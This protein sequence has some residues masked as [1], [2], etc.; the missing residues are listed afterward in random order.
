[1][2]SEPGA[3]SSSPPPTPPP[4]PDGEK[5]GRSAW[6][7]VTDVLGEAPTTAAAPLRVYLVVFVQGAEGARI[8][9]IEEGQEVVFGRSSDVSFPIEDTRISRRHAA[10]RK[11]GGDVFVKDLG[12]RN[13]TKV[14]GEVLR[15]EE[16]LVAAGDT[17][18]LGPAEI[19]V[20]AVTA[21]GGS[22]STVPPDANPLASK[23][24][25]PDDE[26]AEGF[27]G[28]VVADP[29]MQKVFRLARRLG[30]TP[31]T[32]LILGETGSGKEVVAEQIHR[33]SPRV[34]GPFVRLNCASLSETLLESELFGHEKGAF[35][36]AD[37]RKIGYIEAANGGTLLL[38]EIGEL[39][40]QTQVKLLRVLETKCVA[41]LGGTKEVPVDVRFVCAT[42]R[43]LKGEVS[44][45]RF[46]EDLYYRI[47]TFTLQVPPLRERPAEITLL[48]DLFAAHFAKKMDAKPPV[49][50]LDAQQVLH[51]FH[52]PGNV[53]EL[54]NAVEH[55]VVLAE[56]GTVLP[57]HLPDAVRHPSEKLS[58]ENARAIKEQFMEVEKK[59]IEAALAA[60]GQNQTRAAKRL[61]ITR[62]MLI[63]KMGKL[64]IRRA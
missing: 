43:N 61:G 40:L 7:T 41:R 31:T 1:M 22:L 33:W 50:S 55:A 11:A 63:Y 8:V 42:H 5:A 28:I 62:R 56:E 21:A 14:R 36:G 3:P 18:S 9:D 38:D 34:D 25:D 26:D 59:N 4:P 64:G 24:T 19:F 10:V 16:K 35:T 60:E 30:Q 47:S 23:P 17:V 39:P 37:R 2:S 53:R 20:A 6:A 44:A 27:D 51:K 32:V 13:G 49:L 57:E 54:R 52:W 29:A 58:I 12:S 15:G 46:R 45:G 48:A